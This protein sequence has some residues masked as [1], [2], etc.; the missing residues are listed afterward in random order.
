M[1]PKFKSI[2]KMA[3]SVSGDL[4]ALKRIIRVLSRPLQSSLIADA[5]AGSPSEFNRDTD[6]ILPDFLATIDLANGQTTI[7]FLNE[8]IIQV[9]PVVHTLNLSHDPVFA[10]PWAKPRIIN[11][12]KWADGRHDRGP[13]QQ[14]DNHKIHLYL[15]I[16]VG[17]VHNGN[18]SIATGIID[19]VGSVVP[20]YVFDF[21]DIYQHVKSDGDHFI[22]IEDNK[23]ISKV[24]TIEM[25]AVFEI[26][27][28]LINAD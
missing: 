23:R 26:G 13:W 10:V 7:D 6:I 2:M 18:H 24:S 1:N 15:P 20:D 17:L 22:R 5:I 21:S 9:D 16:G 14:D 11:A 12:M 8:K 27:R 25:A 28:L 3:S 19:G 4:A